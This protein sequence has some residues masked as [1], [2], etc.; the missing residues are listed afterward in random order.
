MLCVFTFVLVV[1]LFVF[2]V[3]N[4]VSTST[5]LTGLKAQTWSPW[6]PVH[7]PMFRQPEHGNYNISMIPTTDF[8]P[9]LLQRQLEQQLAEAM[10]ASQQI[11]RASMASSKSDVEN[12]TFRSAKNHKKI[13]LHSLSNRTESLDSVSVK[14]NPF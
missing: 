1:R 9:M 11:R 6:S 5:A 14:S 12:Y 4:L 2:D 13:K 3:T 8:P 10:I 7:H